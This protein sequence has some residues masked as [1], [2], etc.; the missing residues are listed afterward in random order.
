MKIASSTDAGCQGR[1]ALRSVA[2][3][4]SPSPYAVRQWVNVVNSSQVISGVPMAISEYWSSSVTVG[5]F[6]FALVIT[7]IDNIR[8]GKDDEDRRFGRRE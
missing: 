8:N 1:K 7:Y 4:T 2:L 5:E 6:R 3:P